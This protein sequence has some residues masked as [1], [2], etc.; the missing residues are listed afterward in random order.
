VPVSRSATRS[1][2]DPP[3]A[4]QPIGPRAD[5]GPI[6]ASADGE[7]EGKEEHGDDCV[8]GGAL[9]DGVDVQR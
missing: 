2:Q 7:R 5:Q 6:D 3:A 1:S 4:G 9:G 8:I